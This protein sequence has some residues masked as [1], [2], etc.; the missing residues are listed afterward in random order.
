MLV[1]NRSEDKATGVYSV[2][3][4]RAWWQLLPTV[5]Q[6]WYLS[7]AESSHQFSW[8]CLQ[9]IL[10]LPIQ[11]P[12]KKCK[13]HLTVNDLLLNSYAVLNCIIQKSCQQDE[14]WVSL[15]GAAAECT[16]DEAAVQRSPHCQVMMRTM[17]AV[18]LLPVWLCA[19]PHRHSSQTHFKGKEK[20]QYISLS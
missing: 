18:I 6:H 11:T 14:K 10:S 12:L 13:N 9:R 17:C 3:S 16:E 4:G 1:S 5:R 19:A 8:L 15:G 2:L 20:N 7:S